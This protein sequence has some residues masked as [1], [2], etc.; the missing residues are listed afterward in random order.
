MR[1]AMLSLAALLAATPALA[2]P[3]VIASVVPIHSIVAAVMGAA[4][5]PELLLSGQLPEHRASFTAAQVAALGKADLVFIAGRGLEAKLAQLSGSEAVNGKVFIELAA[6]AGVHTLPVRVGGAW[7]ADHDGD[8]PAAD[9]EAQGVLAFD[10]HVWLDPENAKAMAAAAATELGL[11][12][13]ANAAAYGANAKAFA[14]SLDATTAGI[15]TELAP[16]KDRPFIV[17][18]DAYQYFER[19]FGLLAAG[20]ITDI[21]ARAPSAERLKGIRDKLAASKAVCVFRE[22]QYDDKVVTTVTEGSNARGGVLDPLGAGLIPGP[23]AYSELLQNLAAS[24]RTC[25]AG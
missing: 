1:R 8:A 3:R 14:A 16:V 25:L 17:F 20:S 2:A 22:P 6:V 11:A 15:I 18:H 9:G 5:S 7:D 21:S 10:P 19:R 24:I 23:A 13:P 4:G 12:D